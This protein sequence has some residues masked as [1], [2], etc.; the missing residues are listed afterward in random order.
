MPVKFSSDKPIF[1]QLAD[2]IKCD[3]LCGKYKTTEKLPSVR[4]F[5]ITYSINPNTVQKSLQILEEEG[6]EFAHMVKHN[7]D[8][9]DKK[10]VG[11]GRGAAIYDEFRDSHVKASEF[12]NFIDYNRHYLNVKGGS[13]M[14]NFNRIIITSVQHPEHI[15][16]GIA[17]EEPR[18]QWL[19]RMNIIDLTPKTDDKTD[20]EFSYW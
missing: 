17:D 13:Q 3:I 11:D 19:R 10:G 12:I 14:N 20:N 8:F 7:N 2:I 18:K 5:A 4:E 15:Y 6:F 1:L 16:A 9:W